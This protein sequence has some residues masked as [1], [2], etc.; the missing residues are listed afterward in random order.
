MNQDETTRFAAETAV[1]RTGEGRY[2]AVVDKSWWIVAG[3]NGGYVAAIVLRA[4]V[5]E[6]ADATRRPRSMTLQYLRPPRVG[7]VEVEVVVER[8][9]RSVTNVTAKLAQDGR[10]LVVAL[11][12]L[13]VDRQAPTSFNEDPGLP[14]MSDGSP[15]PRVSE[16]PEAPIDPSRD[17]PMRQHYDLRWVLGERPFSEERSADARALSGGWIRPAEA[18][19]IDEVVLAAM[20]DA[21]MPPIFSRVA[22]P[23]A[24]PTIDLTIHFRGLPEDPLAHCFGVFDSPIARD[25]YLVEHG[26]IYSAEGLLLAESRQLAVVA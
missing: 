1:A 5:A 24:V 11:A 12:S 14:T 2:R 15:V 17:I 18:E 8:S 22:E 9:G 6:V 4:I 16:I 25:G 7:A 19:P 3:P 26:K 20:T 23:L 21:W 10:T 13:G